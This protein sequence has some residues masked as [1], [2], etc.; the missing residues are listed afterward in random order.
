MAEKLKLEHEIFL[1]CPCGCRYFYGIVDKSDFEAVE[2]VVC[3]N[4]E[5]RLSLEEANS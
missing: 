5:K 3:V 2:A 1:E 4:C